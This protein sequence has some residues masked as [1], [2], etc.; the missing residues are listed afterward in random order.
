MFLPLDIAS[1]QPLC[2]RVSSCIILPES[3]SPTSYVTS[4]SATTPSAYKL[5]SEYKFCAIPIV[6]PT[7]HHTRAYA[8]TIRSPAHVIPS[9]IAIPAPHWMR[10]GCWWTEGSPPCNIS[11]DVSRQVSKGL[12][13]S[14]QTSSVSTARRMSL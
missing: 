4:T 13:L 12:R 1:R 5:R 10:C 14:S 3:L 9:T 11:A 7:I 6:F 2:S 8:S